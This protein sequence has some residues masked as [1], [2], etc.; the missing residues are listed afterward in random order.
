MALEG[1]IKDFGLADI[2]QLIGIQRK[3]GILTMDDGED[4]VTVKFLDGQ[5]VAADTRLRNLEDLFGSVLVRTGRITEPQLQQALAVQKATLQR[6]GYILIKSAAISEEDLRDALRTQV[7]QIVYR[8][9]RWREGRYHFTPTD[10]VDYD[11]DHFTPVSA[12]T[13]LMEGARMIDEWPMIERRIKNPRMIFRRTAAGE[14]LDRTVAPPV[15][16]DLDFDF[17]LSASKND[18]SEESEDAPQERAILRAV[19]G[20][21]SVQEL[22]DRSPL[23]EFDV[24]RLLYELLNRNLI[25]EV[26]VVATPGAAQ[27]ERARSRALSSALVGV[28]AALA[29]LGLATAGYNPATPWKVAGVR[30]E[31][32]VVKYFASEGRLGRLERAVQVFYLDLGSVP[33]SLDALVEGGYLAAPDLLDPWNRRYTLEVTPTGYEVSGLDQSGR[34][35]EGLRVRRSFTAAQ[36]LLLGSAPSR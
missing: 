6:L 4:T 10:R 19:D 23:G 12:E 11:S 15:A 5:I 16:D 3:T 7:S 9:F 26:K 14:E 27:A 33:Q 30:R 2:L 21:A 31:G 17:D 35:S 8:L 18:D 34:P 22:V 32:D 28:V 24:Y 25:E 1:T 20:K 29:L 36:R 13:I